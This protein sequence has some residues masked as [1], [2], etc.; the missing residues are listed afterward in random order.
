VTGIA[1]LVAAAVLAAGPKRKAPK[2]KEVESALAGVTVGKPV[3]DEKQLAKLHAHKRDNGAA[4][5]DACN[6]RE[7][8]RFVF[9]EE[10]FLQGKVA[11]VTMSKVE[12]ILCSH[13]AKLLPELKLAAKTPRGVKLGAAEKDIVKA[14]GAATETDED[15]AAGAKFLRYRRVLEPT[16]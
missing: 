1:L 8:V 12:P 4:T 15:T 5:W 3:A 7:A 16:K 11:S 14:Y 13:D 9:H 6:H 10:L 2:V